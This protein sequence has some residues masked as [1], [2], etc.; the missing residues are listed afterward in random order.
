MSRYLAVDF[1]TSNCTAGCL[2]DG[3]PQLAT[4]DGDSPYLSSAIYLPYPDSYDRDDD[5]QRAPSLAQLLRE[6]KTVLLGQAAHQAYSQDPLGGIFIRS[7]KSM[8]GSRLTPLQ[9]SLYQQVCSLMLSQIRARSAPAANAVLLGRPVHFQGIDGAEGDERAET[10]LKE[11]ARLA[12]FDEV[13]FAYEPVAAALEYESSL[14]ADQIVLVVDIGGGT[15]DI[16]LLRLGPGRNS[17]LDRSADLLAHAG[18]RLGGVDL[19]IKLA[20]YQL[21]PLF[22]RGSLAQDGKPLPAALFSDAVNIIDI[23][24]QE[25]F[26][27]PATGAQITELQLQ[28]QQPALLGRFRRLYQQHHSYALVQQAEQA[29]I[30][31]AKAAQH[32]LDL[33]PIAPALALTVQQADFASA[34]YME[35]AQLRQLISQCLQQSATA[36]DQIFLTGGASQ[37]P[38]ITQLLQEMLPDVSLIRGDNF[39]SVGKGLCRQAAA[40]FG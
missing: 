19:D 13:A 36:P 33:S 1:G 30:A 11:A 6:R 34:V 14:L 9:S 20:I 16:S 29:K 23:H 28:A 27:Q 7:P 39:G 25:R 32:T 18:R 5:E 10:M 35:L 21:M 8:L 37:S 26:Y 24:A 17:Q 12:G 22:G 3:V 40:L 15:S 31:L 4:L 2:V 38:V